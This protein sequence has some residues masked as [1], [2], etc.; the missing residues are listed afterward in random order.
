MT[1]MQPPTNEKILIDCDPGV[2][3]AVAIAMALAS[4]T[5]DVVGLTTV[6][7]NLNVDQVT[8]NASGLLALAGRSDIPVSKGAAKSL[9]GLFSGGV[10]HVHGTDGL[11]DGGLLSQINVPHCSDKTAAVRIV[12]LAKRYETNGG[13]TIV[14]LGP[15]T[16]LALA[17]QIDPVIEHRVSRVV[18][19][20]G[21]AFCPGNANPA[22]EANIIGD[23]EAA[24][25]VFGAAWPV[26]MIG[27]DVT[28]HIVLSSQQLARIAQNEDFAGEVIR[29]AVPFYR[30]FI[31]QQHGYDGIACHDPAVIAYLLQPDL[32][33]TVRLPVRVET[34][35]VS[36]GKTWP[37]LGNTDD[38]NPA[39]WRNRP[40]TEICTDVNRSKASDL[41]ERLLHN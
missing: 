25:V 30:D 28:R 4:D 13:L 33:E 38:R 19:M 34:Q 12:E 17:L 40:A 41:I 23:P 15:L 18:L 32:F 36:R 8:H 5:L 24:D 35:G 1:N 7:G 22:A 39:P 6:F 11:G 29:K 20:G 16:N 21:N 27:L 10:P 3:D 14:A 2:D 26:T 31:E 37:S 9:T